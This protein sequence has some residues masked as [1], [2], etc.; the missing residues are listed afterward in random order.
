MHDRSHVLLCFLNFGNIR[1][2]QSIDLVLVGVVSVMK[3][4]DAALRLSAT[5]QERLG[6][7]RHL[8]R[9][10]TEYREEMGLASGLIAAS[11]RQIFSRKPRELEL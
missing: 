9:M 10:D 2:L 8:K 4:S 3:I 1:P 5:E 6:W 7:I 11:Q